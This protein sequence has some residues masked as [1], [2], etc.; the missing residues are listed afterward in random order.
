M[1]DG[2]PRG[3]AAGRGIVVLKIGTS[4][5]MRERGSAAGAGDGSV[6]AAA[7]AGLADGTGELALSTLALVVDTLVALKRAGHPVVL[8]TSGAVGV[9][10]RE[11]GMEKRPVVGEGMG[12][13]EKATVMARIQAY[14]AVGQSVL[15][16]IYG[17]M[18]KVAGV[19]CAQVLLPSQDLGSEYQYENA[20]NTLRE[21]LEMGAVPIVNENDTVA[22]E[23]LKYGDNDW[24]SALVSTAVGAEWLFILT[25]VDRLYSGD[26]RTCKNAVGIDIV[27]DVDLLDVDAATGTPIA[28]PTAHDDDDDGGGGGGGAKPG[29]QWGTGGM[30]TKIT[31]AR[32][33]T[34]AGVRVALV[35]GRHPQRVLDF[36]R[37][38]DG[39]VGTVFE[40]KEG[41][42]VEQRE[43]WISQALPP[44]GSVCI[45]QL[46]SSELRSGLV[47]AVCTTHVVGVIGVWTRNSAVRVCG[48]DGVEIGRGICCY[49]SGE[50]QEFKGMD[51]VG[52]TRLL[53]TPTNTVVIHQHDFAMF[54]TLTSEKAP[55]EP[56]PPAGAVVARSVAELARVQ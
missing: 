28:S 9:G 12:A 4:S 27:E 44:R 56:A 47:G 13:A 24:M 25:D 15:M 11:L 38:V 50:L 3:G 35:H 43:Q 23:E 48:E 53:G 2:R 41:R 31:A 6:S 33:A 40:A 54:S 29:S 46:A 34:A 22:T 21:V 51:S 18:F 14:A 36:V 37:G 52:M 10:C 20:K 26:P 49:G 55:V 30:A 5:V 19:R 16:G 7:A 1:S 17:D 39:R 8:V 45:S 42:L 32:L